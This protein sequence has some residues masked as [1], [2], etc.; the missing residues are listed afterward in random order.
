MAD[1]YSV[2]NPTVDLNPYANQIAEIQRR[3][4]MAQ[5]LQQQ[6]MEPLESQVVGGQVIRTSPWQVLAK[7]LQTGMGAYQES[8]AGKAAAELQDQ[9]GSEQR[10]RQAEIESTGAGIAG[11]LF[12]ERPQQY[13]AQGMPVGPRPTEAPA[14]APQPAD[15]SLEEITP[16]AKPMYDPTAALQQAMTPAGTEAMKG[17]PLLASLL[18]QTVKNKFEP[19]SIDK[20]VD[21]GNK[22]RVFYSNGT[23]EDIEKGATPM[24]PYEQE[25]LNILNKQAQNLSD[26]QKGELAVKRAALSAKPTDESFS[27]EA[28]SLAVDDVAAHP[29]NLKNYASFG[30]SGQAK[31]TQ[32]N[33]G[34]AAKLKDSGMTNNDLLQTRISAKANA[35]SAQTL[36]KQA[37]AVQAFEGLAKANGQRV[38][39][40][41]DQLDATG[42]PLAE[43]LIRSV[44][45]KFGNTDAAELRSVLTTFQTEVGRIL[46]NPNMT[47]TVSVTAQNEIRDMAPEN[48]SAAQAR[49]VINRLFTEMELRKKFTDEALSGAVGRTVA[50]PNANA[51]A[52]SGSQQKPDPLGLRQ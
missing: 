24:T 48:M 8:K 16:T 39:A 6:G 41:I 38:L 26:Y 27:P 46:S 37:N 22:T 11:R 29:E 5:L 12:G 51:A 21:L 50:F 44:S 43:G 33:N 4:R 40:L 42:V 34:I 7:A 28:L 52:P 36:Q 25:H 15:G 30:A 47:G 1:N 10:Q 49:R 19:K 13:D 17:N 3:Q 32:I 45:N 35:A 9:I 18:A 2:F 23:T 20:T 14:A 31:R